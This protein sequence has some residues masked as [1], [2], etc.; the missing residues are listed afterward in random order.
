VP[1]HGE[2]HDRHP[3]RVVVR[4]G[5]VVDQA[6]ARR[7][8]VFLE[9]GLIAAVGEGVDFPLGTTVLDASGCLVAPGLVDVHT[10]LREP[11]G[12]EAETV[13]TGTRAASLGGYTAV[14]AMPN[15]EPATDSGAAVRHVLELGRG[16]SADVA[17]AGAITLGRAGERVAPLAE[18]AALGVRLFTDDGSGVQDAVVMRQALETARPLGV[19]LA[20]H[21]QDNAIAAGG[22]M[23]EGTW[24]RRLGI[25]GQPAAAEEAMLD[26]D[27]ALVRLTGTPM[28]FLHV[29]TAG[30]VGLVRA[31]KAAGLP[32]TAEATPHHLLL[33]DALAASGDP[34]YKVAPPLR[35]ATDAAELRAACRAG[36]IDVIATDHA[37]HAAVR[38]QAPFAE[39]PPGMIG[40]ET[41]LAV[42]Y[43]VFVAAPGDEAPLGV[44]ELF[45][46]M[47]WRPAALAG[48]DRSLGHGGPVAPGGRAHLCVFDPAAAWTVDRRAMASRSQ[49]SPY[50][51]MRL[52]GRVRH[53]VL[54]GEPVVVDGRAQR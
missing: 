34:V 14:V 26:R 2:S 31:A 40:L 16:A 13:E 44:V 12:E 43:E 15:T 8:D 51:G 4:G 32:V 38:K 11:G 50:H 36:L 35:S 19:I 5:T 27:V 10:H 37:P 30:S 39:A 3:R 18:M 53:T 24:S 6:G 33:T 46:L 47:S 28:H 21:C 45:A 1:E 20:E 23:H 9:D 29:S 42:V 25:P 49:N 52:S 54:A 17:V 41:A 48:L 22:Q 7:G